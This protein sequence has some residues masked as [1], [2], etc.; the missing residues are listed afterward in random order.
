MP[1]KMFTG[2]ALTVLV[3][4]LVPTLARADHFEARKAGADGNER[5]I[6]VSHGMNLFEFRSG[7]GGKTP[8]E[9]ARIVARRL[10]ELA[11]APEGSAAGLRLAERGGDLIL[12]Q[13]AAGNA[14]RVIVTLDR[15]VGSA[16]ET[17]RQARWKL[18]LLRDHLA[19]ASGQRPRATRGTPVGTLFSKIYG[20][21]NSPTGSVPFEE[22]DRALEALTDDERQTFRVAAN[23]VPAAFEANAA[24]PNAEDAA[25][26]PDK[27]DAT[28]KNAADTDPITPAPRARNGRNA[29]ARR[30]TTVGDYR[31]EL[32]TDPATLRPGEAA[33]I[34]IRL[35]RVSDN[36][37]TLSGATVRAWVTKAG[38]KLSA[39]A[40]PDYDAMDN[41]YSFD[42]TV[43]SAGRC[44]LTIGVLTDDGE[45]FRAQF[46]FTVAPE[47]D[48]PEDNSAPTTEP[49]ARPPRRAPQTRKS[50]DYEVT[51]TL[52]PARPIAGERV[53][54]SLDVYDA[55]MDKPVTNAD[56]EMWLLKGDQEIGD[57][58]STPVPFSD[59]ASVYT[60]RLRAAKSGAYR[61]VA[62]GRTAGGKR[63][64]VTFPVTVVP[65]EPD[66]SE[67][68]GRANGSAKP[69]DSGDE[70]AT[71]RTPS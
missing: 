29:R 16:S 2:A 60:A 30:V 65:A 11:D 9:R 58:D 50:G 45:A 46:P 56:L 35:S 6:V 44:A 64:E 32:V 31:V 28:G 57:A 37:E 17:T 1:G 67:P 27:D 21:L 20:E 69:D 66:A 10:E 24:D 15:G 43:G 39:P 5:G 51:L 33:P 26:I 41:V 61:L 70:Q 22:I 42:A 23:R 40:M 25:T 52:R 55:A 62:R 63:F 68:T 3:A 48:A 53:S 18:A 36:T 59:T 47:P 38:A 7:A 13:E 49:D 34:R 4:L 19:L 54:V 8:G 71:G 14:P 12:Q